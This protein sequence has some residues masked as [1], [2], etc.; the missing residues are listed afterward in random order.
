VTK[1]VTPPAHP[2]FGS[3]SSAA[4][5]VVTTPFVSSGAYSGRFA[6]VLVDRFD[7]GDAGMYWGADSTKTSVSASKFVHPILKLF[8][9]ASWFFLSSV[10]IGMVPFLGGGPYGAWACLRAKTRYLSF[11]VRVFLNDPHC[12]S[13]PQL[14]ILTVRFWRIA[15]FSVFCWA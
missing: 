8:Y 15:K 9:L 7:Q 3:R 2:R 12:S 14:S 4:A 5:R 10:S 6:G 1:I 13:Y 11:D